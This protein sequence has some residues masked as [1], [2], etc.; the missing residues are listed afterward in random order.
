MPTPDEIERKTFSVTLRGFDQTEVT[1]FLY[2]VAAQLED[3]LDRVDA[4][5]PL[6]ETARRA[7]EAVLAAANAEARLVVLEARAEAAKITQAAERIRDEAASIRDDALGLSERELKQAAEDSE[8]VKL[9]AV[10]EIEAILTRAD[11]E[12]S[13]MLQAF[14]ERRDDLLGIGR[15]LAPR[16]PRTP[17]KGSQRQLGE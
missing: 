14:R 7:A 9:K 6:L 13:S 11:A 1:R 17:R 4:A 2:E 3:A 10:D 5:S 16:S 12:V 15:H 8:T